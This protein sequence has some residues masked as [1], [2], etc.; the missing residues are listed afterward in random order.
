M[1]SAPLRFEEFELD[2]VSYELRFKGSP[3]K[4]ERIPMELLLLLA[5]HPGELVTRAEIVEKLWGKDVFL[6]TD[7]SINTAVRKIRQA[8][9]EDPESPRFLHTIPGKG[10]RFEASIVEPKPVSDPPSREVP[11]RPQ[12]VDPP[13]RRPRRWPLGIGLAAMLILAAI[14]ARLYLFQSPT[15]NPGRVML[16]VLPFENLSGDPQQAYFVDGM[17]EEMITQLGSLDPQHLGVIARTSA[18]QYKGAHKDTTQ[19]A[20]E[21]GVNYLLEGSIRRAG[22]RVRVTAQLIQAH[23][24]THIWAGSFD[25]DLNDVLRLQSDVARAIAD[26][27]QLTLSQQVEA[28]LA[29]AHRVNTHAHE[30]YLRGLQAWD[31]RTK[32]GTERSI[33]EFN[34]AIVLD[35]DYG[36][37]YAG[38]AQVYSLAT[39]FGTMKPSEAMP[40]ARD[41][42]M[43]AL[44]I[45]DSLAGAHTTLAFVKAHYDYDWPSAEREYLRALELNP[46]DANAH[47]FYSNSYLSPQGRHDEA[48]AEIK[49]AVELDPLSVPIQSFSGRTYLWAR[50]YDEA[51]AEFQKAA[52][53]NPNFVLNHERLA[54]LYTYVGKFGDAITEET[55]ARMLA[56][57]D[58]KLALTKEDALRTALASRGARGYWETLLEFSNAKENPPQ[59]YVG[60]Y[61][62]VI[63]YARLEEKQKALKS[64][65]QSYS[66]RQ[67]RITELGIEPAFDP[68]RSD[69][70]FQTLLRRVGLAK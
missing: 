64:L 29:R 58:P 57:E 8:L 26:K 63:L 44:T 21:L 48:I 10:Y 28:R 22:E 46:S 5:S 65:E 53:M 3:V 42:A 52:Q 24:Q 4:L 60:T 9:K 7:N 51:L 17:T 41:A 6:D 1:R 50:R 35:Q 66:E 32:E 67:L 13:N 19:I 14:V 54:H 39:L 45:D 12:A 25:R 68:L 38:L 30:A 47:F 31:L 70:R 55:K 37:A 15:R 59:A 11:P 36:L 56:G 69:P 27:I 34:A 40:R 16:V 2:P 49:K 20:R 23:D 18:M 62:I 61:D 33:A 43:R